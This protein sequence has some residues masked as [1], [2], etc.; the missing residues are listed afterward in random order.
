MRV[1]RLTELR[2]TW[3]G[4]NLLAL[5]GILL[6]WLA[7]ASQIPALGVIATSLAHAVEP[8]AELM[9][10]TFVVMMLFGAI[11]Y[12]QLGHSLRKWS[13]LGQVTSTMLRHFIFG[14]LLCLVR[15]SIRVVKDQTEPCLTGHADSANKETCIR[16]LLRVAS[17]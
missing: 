12:T 7:Q 3:R 14:A 15:L 8:L 10:I 1:V 6:N 9:G 4:W 16:R 13:T 11:L 17:A 2:A 5:I